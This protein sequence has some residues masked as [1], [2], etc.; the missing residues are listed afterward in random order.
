MNIT[1]KYNLYQMKLIDIFLH[2]YTVTHNS[3]LLLRYIYISYI[4]QLV[5]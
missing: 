1:K 3:H 5:L 2:S 4:G